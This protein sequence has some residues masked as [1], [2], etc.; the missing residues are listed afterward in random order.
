MQTLFPTNPGMLSRRDWLQFIGFHGLLCGFP[1]RNTASAEERKQSP[2]PAL[3][4]TESFSP[5]GPGVFR[6]PGSSR[7][8]SRAPG[9]CRDQDAGRCRG[10]RSRRPRR[11]S[12]FA[13]V[14]S[15]RKRR[16]NRASPARWSADAYTI[17]KV[18]F[19]SRPQFLV[20]ANLYVPKGRKFPLPGV[21]GTLRAFHQRQGR[22]GLPVLRPGAGPH[23]LRRPAFSTPSARANACSTADQELQAPAPRH[24]SSANTCMPATSSSSSA[25]SS[26]PGGPG[27]ASAPSITCLPARRSIPD[28]SASPATPAAAP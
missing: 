25:S 15:R 19:Q 14:P 12:S 1:Y 10:L 22:R 26:A 27:T 11:R 7:G 28:T 24:R 4:P 3:A 8:A 17:E 9:T 16:C 18:I 23:G 20:T 5:H 2:S 13:L 6:W 21:V